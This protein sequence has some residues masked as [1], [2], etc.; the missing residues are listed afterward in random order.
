MTMANGNPAVRGAGLRALAAVRGRITQRLLRIRGTRGEAGDPGV[1]RLAD[2]FDS[3]ATTIQNRS[4]GGPLSNGPGGGTLERQVDRAIAQVLGGGAARGS[5]GFSRA[6]QGVFPVA[7]DGSVSATPA[8]GL[9]SMY[10]NG[11]GRSGAA[12]AGAPQAGS[13]YMGGGAAVAGG[14]AITPEQ[15]VLHRQANLIA[16]DALPVLKAL[17]PRSE[18]VDADQVAKVRGMIE[19]EIGQLLEE[20]GRLDGPR[21]QRVELYLDALVGQQGTAGHVGDFIG[22]LTAADVSQNYTSLDEQAERA[23]RELLR[24]YAQNLR[25]IWDSYLAAVGVP[26]AGPPAPFSE[27]VVEANQLLT[28]VAETNVNLLA[29]M[30]AI[31][32][33]AG[34]RR[35]TE[36]EVGVPILVDQAASG[37]ASSVIAVSDLTDWLEEYGGRQ[38]PYLVDALGQPGLDLVAEEAVILFTIVSSI[39]IQLLGGGLGIN[40][41]TP[42]LPPELSDER[43]QDE[44]EGLVTELDRLAG[45]AL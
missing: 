33:S 27:R 44:I 38:G 29:A 12:Y 8:R 45:L 41:T 32:F 3:F 40:E 19:L 17:Q 14:G 31:G 23:S 15:A 43:V 42:G 30:D 5:G 11:G 34:E 18:V 16:A 4:D 7:A 20:F 13:G 25:T 6:L 21:E 35:I 1:S 22:L 9:V 39:V 26:A 2:L 28:A 10:A 37:L 36:I 24:Q